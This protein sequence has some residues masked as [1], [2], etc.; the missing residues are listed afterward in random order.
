[1][2]NRKVTAQV[3][4]TVPWFFQEENM[5]LI[6]GHFISPLELERLSNVCVLSQGVAR[7]LFLFE[8]PIDKAITIDGDVYRVVGI[9]DNP[10]PNGAAQSG[11]LASLTA[12][13]FIP[14]H[15]PARAEGG[16]PDPRQQG[17]MSAER[18]ELSELIVTVK[19]QQDVLPAAA[20]IEDM[21]KR[22]HTKQD[23]KLIIPLRLLEEARKT[24]RIFS[25]V[26]G[27]IGRH[28]SAG[29]GHWH[30]EHHAG[31]G[32]R[33][34]ARD[35][36]PPRSGGPAQGYHVPVPGGDADLVGG[37]RRAGH[38]AGCAHPV[39]GDAAFGIEDGFDG[40]S[41]HSFVFCVGVYRC[42]LWA[43]SS[44]PCGAD[45]PDRRPAPRVKTNHAVC[46]LCLEGLQIYPPLSH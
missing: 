2:A 42:C 27:A 35:W 38:G 41:I 14:H 9:V 29:G 32:Q 33:T 30:Y 12:E 25:I 8:D 10:Q 19:N 3:V 22:Y 45:G 17:S 46:P 36:H 16:L 13:C 40:R 4:A 7:D 39:G 31:F 11:E 34:H 15:H 24:Q 5:K 1:M 43:V 26:L 20:L 44:A 18:I 6:A 28:F 21:L 23:Y 37:G